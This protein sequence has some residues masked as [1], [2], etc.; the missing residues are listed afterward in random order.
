MDKIFNKLGTI[1]NESGS[2]GHI[3]EYTEDTSYVVK[4]CNIVD[5]DNQYNILEP[6]I[7]SS[8]NFK[9]LNSGTCYCDNNYLYIKQKRAI[10][11]LCVYIKKNIIIPENKIKKWIF[12]IALC[13][14]FFHD[15]DIIH[16]D[17]KLE[18]IL[19]YD[20]DDIKLTDFSLSVNSNH[21]KKHNKK[22][23]TIMNRPIEILSKLDWDKSVDIWSFGCTIYELYYKKPLFNY[24]QDFNSKKYISAILH[25]AYSGP[26]IQDDDYLLKFTVSPDDYIYPNIVIDDNLLL[27]DLLNNILIINP[28]KRYNID[29]II[30]HA[31]FDDIKSEYIKESGII[32]KLEC[33]N[34]TVINLLFERLIQL[35]IEKYK[36]KNKKIIRNKCYDIY[37]NFENKKYKEKHVILACFILSCKIIE[38]NYIYMNKKIMSIELDICNFYHFNLI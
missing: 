16:G 28:K 32:K 24:Q 38:N 31:Y 27:N 26:I 14:K 12:Q 19:Y 9:Y 35:N 11:D 13:I 30:N 4:K 33:K 10:S 17:I 1:I 18:N 29:D 36:I 34:N 21:I 2:F 7:M 15:N 8:F 37:N 5:G 3:H 25:W 6:I 20:D 22:V 23:C